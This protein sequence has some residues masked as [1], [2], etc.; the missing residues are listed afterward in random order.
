M[1][2]K[3]IQ[4]NKT[5]INTENKNNPKK[6]KETGK[7]KELNTNTKEKNKQTNK[8]LIWTQIP[9]NRKSKKYAKKDSDYNN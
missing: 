7:K 6:N 1:N 4:K 8:I 2:Q 3:Q 5:E 9:T